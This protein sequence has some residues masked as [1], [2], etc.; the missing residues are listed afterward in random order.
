MLVIYKMCIVYVYA[1]YITLCSLCT[2]LCQCRCF[3]WCGV[4]SVQYPIVV[5][6]EHLLHIFHVFNMFFLYFMYSYHFIHCRTHS[7]FLV[8]SRPMPVSG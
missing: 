3:V 7:G 1:Q 2:L 8:E 5:V 4:L 6:L